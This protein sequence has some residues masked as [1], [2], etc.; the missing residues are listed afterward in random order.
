MRE[1]VEIRTKLHTGKDPSLH[2][3][4]T[5]LP[6]TSPAGTDT[7]C[8]RNLECVGWVDTE[9]GFSPN[10]RT[11]LLKSVMK[12]HKA[13]E[14]F[15]P[16]FHGYF[17]SPWLQCPPLLPAPRAHGCLLKEAEPL[18]FTWRLLETHDTAYFLLRGIS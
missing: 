18:A 4:M 13:C 11:V 2:A 10:E 1:R 14:Q 16:F 3:A 5:R 17:R 8:H 12:Y 15:S 9:R 7:L 6:Q